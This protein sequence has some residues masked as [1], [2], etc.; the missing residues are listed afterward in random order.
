[1]EKLPPAVL[2]FTFVTH[3]SVYVKRLDFFAHKRQPGVTC[4]ALAVCGYTKFL[5]V[6]NFSWRQFQKDHV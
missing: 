5:V 6:P 1:M 3:R 4:L 2:C